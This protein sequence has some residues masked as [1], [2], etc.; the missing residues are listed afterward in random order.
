MNAWSRRGPAKLNGP[1][2]KATAPAA[3]GLF[4][5]QSRSLGLDQSETSPT[6]LQ[7]ITY[8]GTVCRS[9]AEASAALHH[10]ADLAVDP[11]QVER[12]TERIGAERVAER[13]AQAAAFQTLPLVEKFRVPPGQAAPDLAVV[14]AD[15]GRLQI[16]ERSPL[17]RS[18]P[19]ESEPVV[20]ADPGWDEEPPPTTGHWREDKVA[21]LLTMK[22]T[23]AAVDSCPE[24]PAGFLDVVRI[25]KLARQLKKNVRASVDAVADGDASEAAA[26]VLREQAYEPPEILSRQVL[27]SRASWPAF[28]PLVAAAAWTLAF[29]GATRRAF[30][31]DGS[32]NNWTLQRRFFG[33]FEPILDFI[34]ALSYVFAAATAGRKFAAGWACYQEWI[35]WV[36]QGQVSQVIAALQQRQA[37]LGVP[38]KDEAETSPPQVVRQTLTYL[39]NHQDKMKYN[40]YRKDGLPITSSLMESAVKQINQRVKGSEKFWTEAGSEAVLQL[41]ADQLSDGEP[42]ADFWQRRQA[43]AT[44]QRRYGRTG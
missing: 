14:M 10:L 30:V 6:L 5:P 33:S 22:S 2:R 37:E 25:P 1:S 3:G 29:Q 44:G 9:F 7:K 24:I 42:L 40:V 13:D 31:G 15:G 35:T 11:K 38:E 41:R 32:A 4:F 20:T 8:A 17:T 18:S 36:W 12:V 28:A 19:A 16:L 26:E 39:E 34:H 23:A 43:T 21:L 27:A